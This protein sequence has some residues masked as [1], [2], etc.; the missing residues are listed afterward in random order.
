MVSQLYNKLVVLKRRNDIAG[1]LAGDQGNLVIFPTRAIQ[2]A[3]QAI[4]ALIQLM[5]YQ[6]VNLK[7]F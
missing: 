5:T 3:K 7:S 1:T 6:F 2:Q 4:Y